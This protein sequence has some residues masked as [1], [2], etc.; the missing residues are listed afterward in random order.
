MAVICCITPSDSYI[1]ETRS[2]LR[3]ATRAKLVKTRTIA[4]EVVDNADLVAGLHR[5]IARARHERRRLDERLCVAEWV[6]PAAPTVERELHNLW[7]LVL[8]TGP[9]LGPGNR[10]RGRRDSAWSRS[11]T[12]A[13]AVPCVESPAESPAAK[14]DLH[15][16][17]RRR[18]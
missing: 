12:D 6:P 2:T 16:L 17:R 15:A 1:E 14:D 4:N 5:E 13:C 7:Q 9:V 3:F 18:K 10:R 8:G 11:A